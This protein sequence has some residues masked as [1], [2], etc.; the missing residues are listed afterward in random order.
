MNSPIILTEQN[1]QL[2]TITLNRPE[3]ANAL[4]LQ[5]LQTLADILK[6]AA[7]DKSLHA[8]VITGA[9]DR[10][11][12]AGADLSELRVEEDDPSNQLWDNLTQALNNLP[13]MSV[14]MLN[15]PCIGGGMSLALGC[16]IRIGVPETRFQ[17]PALKNGVYPGGDDINHLNELIG[18]GRM[19]TLLLGGQSVD[20]EMAVSWGL[21][22]KIIQRED[23]PSAGSTITEIAR[24]APREN[25]MKMKRLFREG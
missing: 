10:V 5:M 4:S 19:S 18:P 15:G 23:L 21:L 20:A 12:C 11:F 14:A 2:L 6:E 7:E 24:N 3:K 16:D 25:V 22:D 13:I 17:Y 1:E 9:G 8:M